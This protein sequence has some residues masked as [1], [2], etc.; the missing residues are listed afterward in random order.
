MPSLKTILAVVSMLAM[1]QADTVKI[2]AQSDNTFSPDSVTAKQGDILEF[3]FQARNHSVV[4]G[5]YTYPC[6]PLPVGS[7]FFSGFVD[8]E[9]GE[10][11]RLF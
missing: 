9:K 6:S 4:A 8:V 1:A 2:T 3:H 7:G 10:A 11:V 5:D